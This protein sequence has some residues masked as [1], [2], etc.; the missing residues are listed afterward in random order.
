MPGYLQLQVLF[1]F[2]FLFQ[3]SFAQQ[4]SYKPFRVGEHTTIIIDGKLNEPEWEQAEA[5]NDFMQIDPVPGA[6]ATDKTEARILYNDEFL[7]VAIHC[8]DSIPSDLIK[9]YLDR[10]FT[11]GEEDGNGFSIDTW[12]D[13]LNSVTF[14]SNCLSAR[15]DA[16]ITGDG[17]NEIESYNTFWDVA[18]HIDSTGYISEYRIPFSSLRFESKP[19]IKMGI[20]ITRLNKRKSEFVTYPFSDPKTE[21]LGANVSYAR[22]M[23]FYNLKSKKPFYISPYLIAGY[24]EAYLLNSSGTGYEKNS[25]LITRKHFVKNE[26]FDKVLSNAGLDIKYGLTKNLTL[27]LTVNTDFAQAEVDDRIINLSKYEVNLP[28]KRSFF[29]ESANNFSFGFPS[30]NELFISRSIGNENGIIVPI[31][32]GA[33]LSGKSNGWQM[34]LLDM[35]TKAMADENIDAHNFFVF[36][37]RKDIDALGSFVGGIITNRQ[38]TN[39]ENNSRQAFGVDFVKRFSQLLLLEGGV[40]VSA[41][42]A[43]FKSLG[44]SSYYNIGLF[45]NVT[46]GFN[47]S[48]SIDV[49]TKNFNPVMGYLDEND[50]GLASGSLGYQFKAGEKSKLEYWYINTH[51]NYRWKLSANKRETFS[52]DL[53]PGLTFKNGAY[54]E[55]SLFDYKIDSLSENW[56]LN[57]HNAISSGTFKMYNASLSLGAP[58]NSNYT[59]TVSS[60]YGGFYGG[61]RFYL[62]PD[63][64]YSFN[65]HFNA[66]LTYEYNHITFPFYFD[67]NTSTLFESNLVRLR[68]TYNFSTKFSIRAFIQ[69]DDLSEQVSSN[70]RIRYNPREGTDLY[71]VLNQGLNSNRNRLEPRLPVINNEAVTLKFVKTLGL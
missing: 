11:V 7:F 34:G 69:Y 26:G 61:K 64:K 25:E 51:E 43:N 35:Q 16:Q 23:V 15:W 29:L 38:N 71:I 31:I 28:E 37:T 46:E 67:E 39:A 65:K 4:E 1:S 36:R 19:E 49:S 42:N 30:G 8:F 68:L 17:A 53:I 66:G 70:L 6:A 47:Y 20:R 32:A 54:I 44:Q 13:K 50:Y 58:S 63:L 56:E 5:I 48:G 10:D 14:I 40:A 2:I 21:N 9:I 22:E 12:N 59:A 60:S 3:F 55:V 45:R 52:S 57:E 62:S 33:R 18:S 24:N 41:D 27:D